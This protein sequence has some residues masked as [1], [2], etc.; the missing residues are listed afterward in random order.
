M[1]LCAPFDKELCCRALDSGSRWRASADAAIALFHTVASSR[2]RVFDLIDCILA[3]QAELHELSSADESITNS[4]ARSSV[5][6]LGKRYLMRYFLLIAFRGYLSHW[7][8][9][10]SAIVAGK[11]VSDFKEWFDRRKELAH[12][13]HTCSI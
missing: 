8:H 13:L 9:C 12:L 5:K 11:D 4:R 1:S 10:G 6:K 3:C 2:H 7:Q